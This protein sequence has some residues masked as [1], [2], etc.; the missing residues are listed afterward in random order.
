VTAGGHPPY[1]AVDER[2]VAPP[3]A[4]L[5]MVERHG[6]LDAAIGS[7]GQPPDADRQ[8]AMA[9]AYEIA[10]REK[11]S[12]ADSEPAAQ[13][14]LPYLPDP[15]A[16]GAFFFGLPGQPPAEPF[17]VTFDGPNWY[18]A[19]P[20]RMVLREGDGPPAWDAAERVLSLSLPQAATAAIRVASLHGGDVREMGILSWCEETLAGAELDA[21]HRAAFENR[22]W[23]LTPWHDIRLVHAVQQP[24]MQPEWAELDVTRDNGSTVAHVLG[25]IGVHPPST[26]K[27]DLTAGWAQWVDDLAELGPEERASSQVVFSLPLNVAARHG[28]DTD[29]R[30]VP[31]S[32]RDE[33]HLSFNSRPRE[34]RGTLPVTDHFFGDTKYRRVSY[35]VVATTS[36]REYFPPAWASEPERLSRRTDEA[37][38]DVPSSAPPA[39]PRVL[40]VV[41]V[42]GAE[43]NELDGTTV[44]RRRGGGVRVY[45]DRPWY[46]SGDG[47]LLGVVVGS[48][49]VSPLAADYPYITLLGQDP[50]RAGQ[51]LEFARVESFRNPAVVARRS[52][53]E[54]SGP[55]E[56]Y[57]IVAYEPSY[58]AETQRWFCDVELDTEAA[59]FPFVRLALVR[60]QPHS[61]PGCHVSRVVRCDI[62]QTLPDRVLTVARDPDDAGIVVL[63]VA[64]PSYTAIAGPIGRR[65][66]PAALGRVTATLEARDPELAD[67]VIAWR[68]LA[69]MEVE[70]TPAIAGGVATWTGRL[71]VSGAPDGRPRRVAVVEHDHLAGDVETGDVV[72]RIVYADV[73]D[74]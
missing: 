38:V 61:L 8:A 35:S 9:A 58:D 72:P 63:T 50:V 59:Y 41:P 13:L 3:K 20:F 19:A 62:V 49:V 67:D 18:E 11:G 68:P 39:I 56:L 29:V 28:S 65:D 15:L 64:G 54:R 34:D 32:L 25:V 21:V 14:T 66:D 27:I 36:F 26:E 71:D 17:V 44:R 37:A 70:L 46:S 2:H 55:N 60:Y 73:V 53:L 33:R 42:Q 47:E 23:M 12:L 7:D 1:E 43:T 74:I 48:P 6:L 22:C 30:L 4:A 10:R 52:L 51:P 40:Y 45:L 31:F 57:S 69:G 5:D 16:T 24:L